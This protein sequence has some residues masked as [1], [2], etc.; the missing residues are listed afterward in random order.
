MCTFAFVHPFL[1]G[2]LLYPFLTGI[3]FVMQ[4]IVLTFSFTVLN[5]ESATRQLPEKREDN[6]CVC[7]FLCAKCIPWKEA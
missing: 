6:F 4:F 2:I 7:A 3:L 5:A 1:T